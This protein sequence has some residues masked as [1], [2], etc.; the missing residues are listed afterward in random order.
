[1]WCHNDTCPSLFAFTWWYSLGPSMLLQHISHIFFIHSSV[2][3]M[4]WL[5]WIVLW[6]LECI[7]LFELDFSSLLG[8]YP[9]VALL[10]HTVTACCFS[11]RINQFTF[12]PAEW[13]YSLSSIPSSA[14]ITCR[15]FD[16]DH[17]DGCE[18]IPHCSFDLHFPDS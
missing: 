3:S 2:A 16:S 5:L 15:L 1:M 18:V 14:F 12:P 9:T 11:Q 13:K 7:Y 17:S 10:G 8:V 6:T 4:S